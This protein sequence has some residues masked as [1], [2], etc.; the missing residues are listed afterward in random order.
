MGKMKSFV[1]GAFFGGLAAGSAVLLLTP[2]SGEEWRREMKAKSRSVGSALQQIKNDGIALKNDI[3]IGSKTSIPA[4]KEGAKGIKLSIDRWRKDTE[5][6]IE[7]L[8][9]QI[10]ELNDQ[11]DKLEET[12][13]KQPPSNQ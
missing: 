9:K 5:P 2:H 7:A 11:L 4:I 10:Q 6:D 8:Q 3:V 13:K 1:T 12:T